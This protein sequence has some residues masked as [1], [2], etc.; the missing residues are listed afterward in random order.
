MVMPAIRIDQNCAGRS[1]KVW[2]R[3]PDFSR[4][5]PADDKEQAGNVVFFQAHFPAFGFYK[6]WGQFKHKGIHTI[7]SVM[8]VD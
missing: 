8:K 2:R 6:G 7:S 4:A 3:P 5:F 1:R